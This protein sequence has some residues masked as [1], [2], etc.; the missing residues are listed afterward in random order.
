MK[1]RTKIICTSLFFPLLIPYAARAGVSVA[2]GLSHEKKSNP[3]PG[4]T[5]KGS[6]LIRNTGDEP[7]EV[8]VYQTDYLF[9]FDGRNIYGQPG[10][11][12]RSNANWLIFNPHRTIIPPNG[13]A[14]VNYTAK[15]PDDPNLVGTYWS[16]LMVEGI[17]KSSPESS[18]AEKGKTKL[19]IT[20]IMR[21]GIQM[22]TH[23]GETGERKL[24]FLNTKLLKEAERRVLQVDLENIGQR[25]LRLSLWV[26]LYDESGR[27]IGKFDGG[28]KRLYPGTSVRHKVDLSSVPKGDYKAM[29]VADCGGDYIFGANYNLKFEK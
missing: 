10:K 15:V 19:G 27:Y 7:Q 4:V 9:F 29:V 28:R 14:T 5:Y 11:D 2:G 17:P 25:W 22:I 6:I 3:G 13:T 23:I 24:K 8:K 26:E 1:T 12:P 21:Y 20:Q 18:E 16:M